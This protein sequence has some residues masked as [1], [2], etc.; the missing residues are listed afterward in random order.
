[1]NDRAR[2]KD[3]GLGEIMLSRDTPN[4]CFELYIRCIRTLDFH[5]DAVL[6]LA[7]SDSCLYSGSADRTVRVWSCRKP[8]GIQ[9]NLS[10]D[11]NGSSSPLS[12]TQSPASLPRSPS[13]TH[14]SPGMSGSRHGSISKLDSLTF[15]L[16][17][18]W[19][20]HSEQVVMVFVVVDR[21]W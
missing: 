5:M 20:E 4:K 14:S 15:T 3:D 6:S 1:M 16:E 18:T 17:H 21:W 8:N 7:G 12:R 9:R 11:S 2:M 10:N 13:M 19:E